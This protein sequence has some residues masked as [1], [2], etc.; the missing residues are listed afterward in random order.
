[1]Q[2]NILRLFTARAKNLNFDGNAWN[3]MTNITEFRK[4]KPQKDQRFHN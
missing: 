1:M 3:L 2:D 4:S